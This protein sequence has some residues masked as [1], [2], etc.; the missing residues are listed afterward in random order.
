MG[1]ERAERARE[2]LRPL[3]PSTRA[4]AESA[5]P[6]GSASLRA[7]PPS[8]LTR[9]WRSGLATA[10]RLN[11]LWAF[12]ASR[13]AIFPVYLAI[14]FAEIRRAIPSGPA[15]GS[16]CTPRQAGLRADA[17]TSSHRL[18]PRDQLLVGSR[19]SGGRGPGRLHVRRR[20]RKAGRRRGTP[21]ARARPMDL[22]DRL[23]DPRRQHL[24]IRRRDE[25][26]VF[27][28][29]ADAAPGRRH[30]WARP[31]RC[32][33]PARRSGP[34]PARA[35]APCPRRSTRRRRARPCPASGWCDA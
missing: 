25:D 28:P 32:R 27:D 10:L 35:S 20:W 31:A 2:L 5:S 24:R 26:V 9:W 17:A 21:S 29:D 8:A 33:S 34:C 6:W 11:R 13:G 1:A 4:P 18:D 3:S 22:L 19:S 12:L 15:R 7:A 14:A 23:R 16:I 30:R